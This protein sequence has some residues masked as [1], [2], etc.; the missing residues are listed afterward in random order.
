MVHLVM[1]YQIVIENI[2]IGTTVGYLL[3][4]DWYA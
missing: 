4:N 1:Q 2:K 3:S